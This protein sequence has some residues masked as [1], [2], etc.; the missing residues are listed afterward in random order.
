[1]TDALRIAGEF[2]E[3]LFQVRTLDGEPVGPHEAIFPIVT[4]DKSGMFALIGTGFFISDNGVF[5]TAKHVITHVLDASGVPIMPLGLFH[6]ASNNTYYFRP[7]NCATR[8]G[9]ADV[10]VGVAQPMNNNLNGEPLK[11]KLL[12]L[13]AE[14]PTIETRIATYAYPKT[15]INRGPPQLINFQGA[16]FGGVI[17]EHF[18]TGRDKVLLPGPCFRTSMVIHGGASGG[19][20]IGPKGTVVGLNS[21]GVG[22]EPLSFVSCISPLLELGIPGVVIPGSTSPQ[23]VSVGHL[24]SLGFILSR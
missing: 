1:M 11:N 18:P 19:P 22:S 12:T 14:V 3:S 9:L 2:P 8:H 20:V 7:I 5:A 17:T 21:T 6:F 15:S 13:S 24:M 16:Y 4:Q 23:T 10:A